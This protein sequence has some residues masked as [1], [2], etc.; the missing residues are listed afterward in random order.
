MA[1][2]AQ[3][4]DLKFPTVSPDELAMLGRA[5]L[6]FA[7]T[8]EGSPEAS[9]IRRQVFNLLPVLKPHHVAVLMNALAMREL[10]PEWQEFSE[11]LEKFTDPPLA[12]L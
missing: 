3:F 4:G 12:V 11:T 1:A 10:T 9:S 7:L 2:V 5:A 8:R 6:L